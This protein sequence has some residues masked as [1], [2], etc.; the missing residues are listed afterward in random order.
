VE[1]YPRYAVTIVVNV[2]SNVVP[3]GIV[4]RLAGVALAGAPVV[5]DMAD[6]DG[7]CETD[8]AV[9]SADGSMRTVES[10]RGFDGMPSWSPDGRSLVWI[11]NRDEQN[12]VCVGDALGS[13]TT[14]LTD[15]PALDVLARWSPDGTS[16]AFSS[17]RDGDPELFLMAPD[18]TDV[19]QLTR[20]DSADW[21]GT[22]S[23][24][25]SQIAYVSGADEQHLRVLAVDGS[26]DHQVVGATDEPWWPTWSPDGQRIAYESHGV[27]YIVPSTGG[28]PVR[29]AIPQIRVTRFPAWSPGSDIAFTSDGDIYAVAEDGSDL[30]RLT[31][32][33]TSESTP[34]WSPDGTTIAFEVAYWTSAADR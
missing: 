8:V 28:E 34:A 18:G 23:P 17:D 29:L 14:R 31:E 24:D 33:P 16:I 4:D 27:I 10:A 2:N 1:H 15:D 6:M 25:G 21:M 26:R 22:W 11:G 7:E 12:D 19:R 20:N 5:R 32:T 3:V 13:G 30:R 9:R